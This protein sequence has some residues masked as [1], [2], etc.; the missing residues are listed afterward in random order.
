MLSTDFETE[1]G[2][3]PPTDVL[4]VFRYFRIYAIVL[5]LFGLFFLLP[6]FCIL[7]LSLYSGISLLNKGI[8][9][10]LG[11]SIQGTIVYF[12]ISF[13]PYLISLGVKKPKQVRILLHN[14]LLQVS[15]GNC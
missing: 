4:A 2:L 5:F 3:T 13:I 12:F 11:F 7:G 8:S 14:F 10:F 15:A 1:D 6:A 9:N